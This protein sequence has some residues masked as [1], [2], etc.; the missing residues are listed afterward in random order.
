M[1]IMTKVIYQDDDDDKGDD[2]DDKG[3]DDD[4]KGDVDC[5]AG[6]CV[7]GS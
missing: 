4:D 2:D 3:D 5:D 1:M 6:A 7:D